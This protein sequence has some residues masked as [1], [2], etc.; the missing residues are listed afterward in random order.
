M[1][2]TV[3]IVTHLEQLRPKYEAD[4]TYF[5][6]NWSITLTNPTTTPDI[7]TLR[8]L[9]LPHRWGGLTRIWVYPDVDDATQ[10]WLPFDVVPYGDDT[11]LDID[12]MKKLLEYKIA[13]TFVTEDPA[14][15]A[16]VWNPGNIR[17]PSGHEPIRNVLMHVA[18]MPAPIPDT[19][20]LAA[21]FKVTVD[22]ST[23]P[24]TDP[25][26][27]FKKLVAVPVFGNIF[28]RPAGPPTVIDDHVTVAY[29]PLAVPPGS[30][31]PI[32]EFTAYCNTVTYSNT[33]PTGQFG[34]EIE[35][36]PLWLGV[37]L[38]ERDWLSD[39]EEKVANSLTL[40]EHIVAYAYARR[41]DNDGDGASDSARL[42][43]LRRLLLASARD[44]AGVGLRAGSNGQ[45][46]ADAILLHCDGVD[47]TVNRQAI[48][49]AVTVYDSTVSLKTWAEVIMATV[50]EVANLQ[51][52]QTVDVSY[53]TYA[54]ELDEWQAFVAAVSSEE[55]VKRLTLAQWDK[56]VFD[57]ASTASNDA[58][59]MWRRSRGQF[60]GTD[61]TPAAVQLQFRRRQSLGV[62]ASA[63][64]NV[65]PAESILPPDLTRAFVE[66][67]GPNTLKASAANALQTYVKRRLK[68]IVPPLTVPRAEQIPFQ[69]FRPSIDN[70][71]ADTDAPIAAFI[72]DL[73]GLATD[74]SF[75]PELASLD[76]Q[77][78]TPTPDTPGLSLFVGSAGQSVGP[79]DD[80]ADIGRSFYGSAL[81]MRRS[82]SANERWK[83]LN[84]TAIKVAVPCP[85][86]LDDAAY[87]ATFYSGL[88][89]A[90]RD[91]LK[92]LTNRTFASASDFGT[93]LTSFDTTLGTADDPLVRVA[94]NATLAQAVT[95]DVAALAKT[96]LASTEM[97]RMP[98]RRRFVFW[99]ILFCLFKSTDG[100]LNAELVH[101]FVLEPSRLTFHNGMRS[102]VA[103]YDDG[104]IST[105][106]P[107]HKLANLS[108]TAVNADTSQMSSTDALVTYAYV[109]GSRFPALAPGS[110]Y[111]FAA[112]A[113]T[114]G[115]ALPAEVSLVHPRRLAIAA[116]PPNE[117]AAPVPSVPVGTSLS[118]RRRRFIGG[119][120]RTTSDR[121]QFVL[122]PDNNGKE[123]LLKPV[124]GVAPLAFEFPAET[125]TPTPPPGSA[126]PSTTARYFFDGKDRA[127]TLNFDTAD[128][129]S[130][131]LTRIHDPYAKDDNAAFAVNIA[132]A[133][134]TDIVTVWRIGNGI[135]VAIGAAPPTAT[136]PPIKWPAIGVCMDL[137]VT[138][139][140][141][142]PSAN[143]GRYDV[144]VQLDQGGWVRATS[145]P[146]VRTAGQVYLSVTRA[147]TNGTA[148]AFDAPTVES[149]VS[150]TGPG[151][152]LVSNLVPTTSNRV[153]RPM[154]LLPH[155]DVSST[156]GW[157]FYV[158][159]PSIDPKTYLQWLIKEKQSA[160][161]AG[162]IAGYEKL[163]RY[164]SGSFHLKSN[165]IPT[166]RVVD[167]PAVTAL[168]AEI[169]PVFS[170][171]A[172]LQ[173]PSVV[174]GL[175]TTRKRAVRI[176]LPTLREMMNQ[177][178][179][180]PPATDSSP[181][182]ML[183]YVRNSVST[184]TKI[185]MNAD[186][187]AAKRKPI[188]V[189]TTLLNNQTEPELTYD[190]VAKSLKVILPKGGIFE[191]RFYSAVDKRLFD[192]ATGRFPSA[193]TTALEPYDDLYL[194]GEP[195][196]TVFETAT[197]EMPTS[198]QLWS[199][200]QVEYAADTVT[201]RLDRR[202]RPF[203]AG[204]GTLG[205]QPDRVKFLRI[206]EVT[207]QRQAWRPDGL[208][209]SPIP[210]HMSLTPDEVSHAVPSDDQLAPSCLPYWDV[211]GF[212]MRSSNEGAF[213]TMAAKATD[214][215]VLLYKE[216][217]GLPR[218]IQA[219][220]Y[221]RFQV[222]AASRYAGLRTLLDTTLFDVQSAADGS[223][224]GSNYLNRDPWRRLFV[225][226][227][228]EPNAPVH[229]LR[230]T[231]MVPLTQGIPGDGAQAEA[232]GHC[233][234]FRE[235]WYQTGPSESLDGDITIVRTAD[236][237]TGL[238]Q[239]GQDVIIT[240]G[241]A[242]RH[243][244]TAE[245]RKTPHLDTNA[246]FGMT[247]D[248]HTD[249]AY[250]GYTSIVLA[251]RLQKKTQL[252]NNWD[253][254]WKMA[255]V[256][257]RR[258]VE[259]EDPSARKEYR[260][261]KNSTTGVLA[262][263][264]TVPLDPAARVFALKTT[265]IEARSLPVTIQV[266][267]G[268]SSLTLS[269]DPAGIPNSARVKLKIPDSIPFV[270]TIPMS[271]FD[272]GPI[273]TSLQFKMQSGSDASSPGYDLSVAIRGT[274]T[275]WATL[276]IKA[277][278]AW[279][280]KKSISFQI[281]MPPM[282]D[283]VPGA[284]PVPVPPTMVLPPVVDPIL[285]P[286]LVPDSVVLAYSPLTVA[287]YSDWTRPQWVQYLPDAEAVRRL[288]VPNTGTDGTTE[289][290]APWDRSQ[291][292]YGDVIR[293]DT[294]ILPIRQPGQN[295]IAA[296][297][298]VD[299]SGGRN[300]LVYPSSNIDYQT[301][302]S[303]SVF[304]AYIMLTKV[305]IDG[306]RLDRYEDYVGLYR[307]ST[308]LPNW[309]SQDNRGIC[310]PMRADYAP[311]KIGTEY[312]ARYIEFQRR[313]ES[314]APEDK[315][316]TYG[317]FLAPA[318]VGNV[319][320]PDH[321]YD[322]TL[323]NVELE[324][325][326]APGSIQL[327]VANSDLSAFSVTATLDGASTKFAVGS[328]FT[329]KAVTSQPYPSADLRISFVHKKDDQWTVQAFGAVDAEWIA[330]S[331]EMTIVTNDAAD[332][333]S[334]IRATVQAQS[335]SPSPMSA[336]YVAPFAHAEGW[337][338]IFE[339]AIDPA[340]GRPGTQLSLND[341]DGAAR[342]IRQSSWI[343]LGG[344][345]K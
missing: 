297:A 326:S 328:G 122:S 114:A 335:P 293:E 340:T 120:Q 34:Y 113:P 321:R 299:E 267:D 184:P 288:I 246:T 124:E 153:H 210:I 319:T 158:S 87:A 131:S 13:E 68:A 67:E 89:A 187:L 294:R 272:D 8:N 173:E 277:P 62:I 15:S 12:P 117:L 278:C 337:D 282:P 27:S 118:Y 7:E 152:T 121:K 270:W 98:E 92:L 2:D 145:A 327:G 72:T 159:S 18:T 169:V 149:T 177:V 83:C 266:T 322:I 345:A 112:F 139:T 301:A 264:T 306:R 161:A 77:N 82:E 202:I 332:L 46:L 29:A 168:V 185:A 339:P 308:I 52:L 221:Y 166:N 213:S 49:D 76:F 249:E 181:A 291:W 127:G 150:A 26:T 281:L 45:S 146:A 148:V 85:R 182:D 109:A 126:N 20:N 261:L 220:V 138:W 4:S 58:K 217:K 135:A 102:A 292:T 79:D 268:A 10:T 32:A 75:L 190:P 206:G 303:R 123:L 42:L 115:R 134:R 97:S 110:K 338:A 239:F 119:P 35:N 73:S 178:T 225:P 196:R 163:F 17:V 71:V 111:E 244:A 302:G 313:L 307:T 279:A 54:D 286:A 100:V 50:P 242:D 104:P 227:R 125:A 157:T 105:E 24:P 290:S 170:E 274:A 38:H 233:A 36:K 140:A 197:E 256:Q 74:A 6:V 11:N 311:L 70:L 284:P 69:N 255:Q 128:L 204:T 199:A 205:T 183:D 61:S 260:R 48:L 167:D 41:A 238:R 324:A 180:T 136:S 333:G 310:W 162:E 331:D 193:W 265:G 285:V 3:A 243:A 329:T 314:I 240:G 86:S 273:Q 99:R 151:G 248:A 259:C 226:A 176:A 90:Q 1:L 250:F 269:I 64:T 289:T 63:W 78:D 343:N 172:I 271:L 155:P 101:P 195:L 59:A 211:E 342:R 228:R 22:T 25:R 219:A 305:I 65:T 84:M 325:M 334:A 129:W 44:T 91:T 116:A 160:T 241:L 235:V 336:T 296:F 194:I 81:L 171:Q 21:V 51:M 141:T 147:G 192:A 203:D 165:S 251:P 252:K 137:R 209:L 156:Q 323:L 287:I 43:P 106:S 198:A 222:S 186:L 154:A 275:D 253:H 344:V 188:R 257:M 247:F 33:P 214:P 341:S 96:A 60:I 80:K 40:P 14:A 133:S 132:N 107:K 5:S 276:P 317:P 28:D 218:G 201:A 229:D 262:S 9:L 304:D 30:P 53:T 309:T 94:G 55:N 330:L 189:T 320:Q 179:A 191:L 66:S 95:P 258:R 318:A 174:T 37:D 224:A 230:L 234:V 207:L 93:Y 108:G 103:R 31:L 236:G 175:A 23:E 312:R 56:A 144:D 216:V 130:I 208:P 295:D 143:P 39:L 280:V 237:A 19:L 232:P 88:S 254:G 16:F 300:T 315:V 231:F 164:V 212:A 245:N 316:I 47:P 298:F 283:P 200:L 263:A 223:A 215:S 57:P 142:N